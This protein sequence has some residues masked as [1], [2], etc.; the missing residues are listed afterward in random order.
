MDKDDTHRQLLQLFYEYV[1]SNQRWEAKKSYQSGTTT[2]KLLSEIRKIAHIRQQEIQEYR[3]TDPKSRLYRLT[4]EAKSH[5]KDQDT[6][7]E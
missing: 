1:V 6:D 5:L 7:K 2:R 3:R 4:Q